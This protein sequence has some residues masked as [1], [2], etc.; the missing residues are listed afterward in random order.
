MKKI[1][2]G[3]TVHYMMD[4]RNPTGSAQVLED[5]RSDVGAKYYIYGFE[6]LGGNSESQASTR[7]K[8]RPP[9]RSHAFHLG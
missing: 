6:L 2:A 9:T 4:S 1:A 8:G 5:S 3:V 7:Q